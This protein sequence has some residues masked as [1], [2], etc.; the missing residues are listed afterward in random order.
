MSFTESFRKKTWDRLDSKQRAGTLAALLNPEAAGVYSAMKQKKDKDQVGAYSKTYAGAKFGGKLGL[1]LGGLGG[2]AGGLL[3]TKYLQ[4]K[5]PGKLLAGFT[6][7][8]DKIKSPLFQNVHKGMATA[9]TGDP[10]K[11][12]HVP[13]AFAIPAVAGLV[14]GS[15]AGKYQ[16]AKKAHRD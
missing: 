15:L 14:G 13:H 11:S 9:L 10:E 5:N 2:A 1:I 7:N 12:I 8:R 16:G 4:G 3:L 6:L